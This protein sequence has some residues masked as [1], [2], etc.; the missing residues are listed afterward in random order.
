MLHSKKGIAA[1]QFHWIFVLIAGG[2][3]LLFF[4]MIISS[5]KTTADNKMSVSMINSLDAI[6]SGSKAS[7]NTVSI[8]S[9]PPNTELE[10]VCDAESGESEVALSGSIASRRN[11]HKI[12]FSKEKVSGRQY[13]IFTRSINLPFKIDNAL[14][15]TDLNTK[16]VVVGSSNYAKGLMKLLPANITKERVSNIDNI[17]ADGYDEVVIIAFG[18]GILTVPKDLSRTK[19]HAISI[20][21]TSAKPLTG[22]STISVKEKM[23]DDFKTTGT[24][25]FYGSAMMLGTIFSENADFYE[26]AYKN[27]K[28]KAAVMAQIYGKRSAILESEVPSCDHY[29]GEAYSEFTNIM[30][31]MTD[32]ASKSASVVGLT[33]TMSSLKTINNQVEL[34]SCPLIY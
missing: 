5:G 32:S 10:F 15:V 13:V 4:I 9:A 14:Y 23:Q 6:F 27:M 2:I 12:L 31:A 30:S 33:E 25:S 29:Y 11:A 21:I 26:C 22:K 8:I 20:D 7:S 3:I 17:K 19:I 24:V 18:G 16:Y 28:K 1:Q 34:K